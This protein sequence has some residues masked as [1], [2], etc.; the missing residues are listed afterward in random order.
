MAK[1][2]YSKITP[3]Q[4]LA[5]DEVMDEFNFEKVERHMKAVNWGWKTPTPEDEYNLE[6]PDLFTI[7][8]ACRRLLV[9][10]FTSV[11]MTK[12]DDCDYNGPCISSCGGFTVYAWPDNS[13]QVYFSVTD[14]WV[15]GEDIND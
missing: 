6:V 9:N 12:E 3:E 14:W 8:A 1:L 5:I 13:C 7:K 2:D 4:R 15:D 11:T 10:A